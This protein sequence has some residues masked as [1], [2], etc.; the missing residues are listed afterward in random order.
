MELPN[1]MAW[2]HTDENPQVWSALGETGTEY[3]FEIESLNGGDHFAV[4]NEFMDI[5]MW[6]FEPDIYDLIIR[7]IEAPETLKVID[8]HEVINEDEPCADCGLLPF[9]K[10]HKLACRWGPF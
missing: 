4:K 3:V 1:G 2:E 7:V 6:G 8:P 5:H 10:G 9:E